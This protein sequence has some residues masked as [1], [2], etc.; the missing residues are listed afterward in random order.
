VGVERKHIPGNLKPLMEKGLITEGKAHIK[1][2]AQR[3]KVYLPTPE[4]REG[5]RAIRER[6]LSTQVL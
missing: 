3:R 6:V 4:E 2:A 1:G 5:A